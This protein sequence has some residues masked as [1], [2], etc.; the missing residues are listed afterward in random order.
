MEKC[1]FQAVLFDLDGTLTNT[2][3]DIADAMNRTL[4]RHGLP[5]WETDAYR[6]MVGNGPVLLSERAAGSRLEKR[7]LLALF[8][9]DQSIKR[10]T[11]ALVG[12]RVTVGNGLP[13]LVLGRG[14]LEG[15]DLDLGLSLPG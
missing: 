3:D 5:E 13:I 14:R 12:D 15:D 6:Y 4:R 1:S 8:L 2:L 7:G 10:R 11:A 9:I